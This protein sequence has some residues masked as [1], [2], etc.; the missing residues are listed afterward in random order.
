MELTNLT[1]VK[2]AARKEL[3]RIPGVEGFG[4]GDAALRV[5]VHD[6]AVEKLVPSEFHGVPVHCVVTGPILPLPT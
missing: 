3:G 6:A 4:I 5:Y 2:A 1:T